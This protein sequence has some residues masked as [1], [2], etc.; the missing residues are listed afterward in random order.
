MDTSCSFPLLSFLAILY[1]IL[2][3]PANNWIYQ[4]HTYSLKSLEYALQDE[5]IGCVKHAEKKNVTL[6]LLVAQ[7]LRNFQIN[8]YGTSMRPVQWWSNITH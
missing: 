4:Q 8:A 3:F 7:S 2:R 1:E 6:P 5:H